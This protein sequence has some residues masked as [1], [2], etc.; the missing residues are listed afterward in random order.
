MTYTRRASLLAL[1]LATLCPA[2]ASAQSSLSGNAEFK[3]GGYIPNIDNE[4]A[5][6][7]GPYRDFFGDDW[8]L[9]AE[10]E[11][12][13]YILRRLIPAGKLG[14]GLHLGYT[15]DT[16]PV[17]GGESAEGDDELPGETSLTVIP[18]RVSLLYRFD[19]LAINHNIPFVPV[20]KGGLDYYLWSISDSGGDRA[21]FG[22]DSGAGGRAG[23][24][25]AFSLQFLLDVIDPGS[26]AY[27]DMSWG[28]NNSYFFAEYMITR[29]D[30]FGSP[31][32]DLSDNMWMFGLAFEF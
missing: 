18:L 23:W 17:R 1:T 2:M 30:G 28:V 21:S 27:M 15:S 31:G 7:Q 3:L 25:G 13:I 12:D 20:F 5:G 4:F 22:G 8:Q 29:I 14:I 24:H 16:A 10:M 32:F 9:Y 11:W 26:A 6:G 19:Y